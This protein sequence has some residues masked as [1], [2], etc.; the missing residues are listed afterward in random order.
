MK[1]Y[2]IIA[3]ILIG[4]IFYACSK[5]SY[6]TKPQLK[7]KKINRTTLNNQQDLVIELEFTDAEGD[8]QDTIWYQRISKICPTQPGVNVSDKFKIPNVE[9]TS[10]QKGIFEFKFLYGALQTGFIT[11]NGCS[12]KND[13]SYF[14]FWMKDKAKNYSD[15]I[16]TE[17]IVF[18][19]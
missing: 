4:L 11:L 15:T 10:N 9:T 3:S 6:T 8:I 1:S 18:I 7:V 12:N 19:K 17:N 14:K 13:T 2:T 5:T 16:T